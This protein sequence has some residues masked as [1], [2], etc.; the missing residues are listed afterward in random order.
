MVAKKVINFIIC[1]GFG[2]LVI[3]KVGKLDLRRMFVFTF[4]G[5]V[6]VGP[7]LHVW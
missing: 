7:T 1:C 2:Q 3:E 4:L 6:L 5:L